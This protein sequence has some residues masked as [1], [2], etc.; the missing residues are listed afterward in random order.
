[1]Y[2]NLKEVARSKGY[3]VGSFPRGMW[4]TSIKFNSQQAVMGV[5]EA[6]KEP[7]KSLCEV[8]REYFK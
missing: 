4:V 5:D 3:R 6:G 8:L 2:N 7:G 1:M